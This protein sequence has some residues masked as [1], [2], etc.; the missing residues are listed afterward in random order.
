MA[1]YES[2]NIPSNGAIKTGEIMQRWTHLMTLIYWAADVS[3]IV[4]FQ[5][6]A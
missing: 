1:G 3:N 4:Q 2:V 5:S 6:Y